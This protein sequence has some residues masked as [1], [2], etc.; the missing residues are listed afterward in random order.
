[1]D[2]W[3]YPIDYPRWNFIPMGDTHEENKSG[4]IYIVYIAI[5]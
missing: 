4:R 2:Q 5:K 1:M 3:L